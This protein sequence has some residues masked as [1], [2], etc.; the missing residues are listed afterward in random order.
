M[1]HVPP[2]TLVAASAPV[3]RPRIIRRVFA[4]LFRLVD[5]RH[6]GPLLPVWLVSLAVLIM[7]A[8]ALP[9]KANP[10][11]NAAGARFDPA[12]Q[13][14]LAGLRH[15]ADMRAMATTQTNGTTSAFT[16]PIV[17]ADSIPNTDRGAGWGPLRLTDW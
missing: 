17:A 10:S 14:S 6:Q 11:R 5:I 15:A 3:W 12:P 9:H 4:T 16:D 13:V 2:S 1:I 8:A 7:L